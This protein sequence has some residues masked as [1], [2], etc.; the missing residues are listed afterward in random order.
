MGEEGGRGGRGR[1][2]ENSGGLKS[3]I[4]AVLGLI[5]NFIFSS[6]CLI[7]LDAA[8]FRAYIFRTVMSS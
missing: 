4:I 7:K 3:S 6:V 1:E 2:K 5:Y 8:M